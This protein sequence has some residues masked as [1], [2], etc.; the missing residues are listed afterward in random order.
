MRP[1]DQ[2]PVHSGWRLLL[3][4][5]GINPANILRRAHL[6]ADLFARDDATVSTEGV[7][8]DQSNLGGLSFDITPSDAQVFIEGRYVGTVGQFTPTTQPLGVPSGR[9]H[10]EIRDAGYQTMSF[11]VDVVAGQVIPYQGQMER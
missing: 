3:R 4:D 10:V 8:P 5:L 9:H 7:Q 11:D 2:F 1:A 6:P